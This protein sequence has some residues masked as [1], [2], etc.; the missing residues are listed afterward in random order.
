MGKVNY[1]KR[2]VGQELDDESVRKRFIRHLKKWH[3]EF[4]TPWW[5]CGFNRWLVYECTI[6]AAATASSGQA[7]ERPV[8]RIG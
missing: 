6:L 2:W 4:T 1:M 8:C 7:P 3:N 5:D